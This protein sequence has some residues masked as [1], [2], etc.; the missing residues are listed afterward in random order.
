MLTTLHHPLRPCC[1]PCPPT[2]NKQVPT[3]PPIRSS[4]PTNPCQHH[5]GTSLDI[6][7]CSSSV[8]GM[9]PHPPPMPPLIYRP[10][11]RAVTVRC[12]TGYSREESRVPCACMGYWW[13]CGVSVL[14]TLWLVPGVSCGVTGCLYV[15]R[16]VDIQLIDRVL[17]S[18]LWFVLLECPFPSPQSLG[19][20]KYLSAYTVTSL[21]RVPGRRVI[22]GGR[23]RDC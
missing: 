1:C 17:W 19:V 11:D 15:R 6:H 7:A 18:V 16:W 14:L 10:T 21:T 22:Y 20:C 2:S 8:D 23:R 3:S 5:R 4:H 12:S 9:E 13:C